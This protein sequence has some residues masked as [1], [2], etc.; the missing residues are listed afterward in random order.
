MTDSVIYLTA[1]RPA[2]IA[3]RAK[4]DP[5]IGL[6]PRLKAITIDREPDGMFGC[7]L[8]PATDGKAAAFFHAYPTAFKARKRAH[9]AVRAHPETF[10]FVVDQSEAEASGGDA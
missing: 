10:Q 9:N 2:A 6:H 4:R 3:R 7:R 5:F 1:A 8:Y